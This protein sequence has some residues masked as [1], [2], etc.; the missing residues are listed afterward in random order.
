MYKR[1]PYRSITEENKDEVSTIVYEFCTAEFIDGLYMAWNNSSVMDKKRIPILQEAISL[2][3]GRL[4]YGCVSILVCQL[5][6]IITDIYN[7]QRQYGKD[8]DLED[9]KMAYQSFNPQKEVPTRIKKDSERTQLLWFISDAEEG[10]MY[11]I[12][13][14]E[15]IYNIILTSE[16]S[17][18]QSRHPCRNKI[19]H[20]IQLNFGTREHALKSILTIDMMIRLGEN[21]KH[22]NENNVE[23][24]D[25]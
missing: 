18:N 12:K 21:L 20:G 2:Y 1:Q 3:N 17:M 4:Y 22:I 24:Q 9:V 15:Y 8:F 23:N 7:M 16:D 10:L 11:W 25:A 19:C 13:S 5:N 14:I 6:G